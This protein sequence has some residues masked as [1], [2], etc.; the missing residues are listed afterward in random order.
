MDHFQQIQLLPDPEF[1]PSVLMNVLFGQLHRALVDQQSHAIGISFPGTPQKGSPWGTCLRLHGS[2]DDLKH[3]MGASWLAGM[4]DHT[5]LTT[6]S[7]VPNN[8]MYRVV[9]RVQSKSSPERLRRRLAKRKG[10][11]MEQARLAIPDSAEKRLA[12]PFVTVRSQ[13][14]GHTFRLFIEQMPPQPSPVSGKFSQYGL[15]P[16]ATVPWF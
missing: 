3:L 13:S 16:T 5:S 2:A 15:S 10:L 6:P 11:T 4:R 7:T 12:L 1:T 9:R 14:S 8:I